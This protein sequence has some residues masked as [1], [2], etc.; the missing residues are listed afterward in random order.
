[1][2]MGYL[3]VYHCHNL[4]RDV[5][6]HRKVQSNITI[7]FAQL[8]LFPLR[9][10]NFLLLFE[11][12][13]QSE[14]RTKNAS[15]LWPHTH[16]Q[17]LNKISQENSAHHSKHIS[18]LKLK[19]VWILSVDTE[20]CVSCV[21]K[22]KISK[23]VIDD[24]RN[25][26]N[27]F[28]VQ[29]PKHTLATFHS[30][31]A[32]NAERLKTICEILQCSWSM[33]FAISKQYVSRCCLTWT[34]EYGKLSTATTNALCTFFDMVPSKKITFYLYVFTHSHTHTLPLIIHTEHVLHRTVCLPASLQY[35]CADRH[36][37]YVEC[38]SSIHTY[39]AYS[40]SAIQSTITGFN[41]WM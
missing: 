36:K 28:P 6:P 24:V 14:S 5:K 12:G 1:M 33:N 7:P 26:Q 41:K 2:I 29:R 38:P 3:F 35:V 40:H 15:T 39:K 19:W 37:L 21:C 30:V 32:N 9:N 17:S 31:Y 20:S 22:C 27:I 8:R 11:G 16:T 4:L 10:E 34:H 23:L 25:T 13:I 18:H